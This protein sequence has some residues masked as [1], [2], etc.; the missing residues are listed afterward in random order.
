MDEKNVAAAFGARESLAMNLAEEDRA[1]EA[2]LN[3]IIWRSVKGRGVAMPPPR[4][5]VFAPSS[6][7]NAGDADGGDDERDR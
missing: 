1:P 4:R 3:E 7:P 5:S 6:A 2:L